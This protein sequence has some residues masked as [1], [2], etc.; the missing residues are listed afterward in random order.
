[1]KK[2][3]KI[4]VSMRLRQSTTDDFERLKEEKGMTADGLMRFLINAV[5]RLE[6]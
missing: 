1:M 3:N 2:E 6:G 4:V 5:R